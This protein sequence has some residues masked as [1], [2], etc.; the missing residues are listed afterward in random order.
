MEPLEEQYLE[1][2]DL[3]GNEATWC[4]VDTSDRELVKGGAR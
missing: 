1:K 2:H 4:D 3:V